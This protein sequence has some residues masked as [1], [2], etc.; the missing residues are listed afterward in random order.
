MEQVSFSFPFISPYSV[1][2]LRTLQ[3]GCSCCNSHCDDVYLYAH[4][5][6]PPVFTR[7]PDPR[8]GLSIALSDR[9]Q[10]VSDLLVLAVLAA[11][12]FTF[13]ALAPEARIPVFAAILYVLEDLVQR[14]NRMASTQPVTS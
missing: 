9:T 2:I 11:H 10:N 14:R 3:L 4:V 12:I 6:L 8:Y 13:W 1:V 7:P 5:N